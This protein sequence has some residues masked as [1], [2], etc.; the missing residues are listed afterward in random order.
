[1]LTCQ[2][3]GNMPAL[4]CQYHGW[5]FKDDGRPSKILEPRAFRPWDRENALLIPVRLEKVGGLYFATLDQELPSLREWLGQFYE[6]IEARYSAPAWKMAE[7]WEFDAPCNWKVPIENTLESYHIAE[8][9]PTW[10]G[11]LLPDE[12][13]SEHTL[14]DEWTTLRYRGDADPKGRAAWVTKQLGGDVTHFYHHWHIHPN[15]TFVMTDTFNY[16]AS[17][18][19]TGPMTCRVRTRMFPLWGTGGSPWR[20]FVRQTA[21]IV[22][23]RIMKTIFNEDRTVYE[24]QQRGIT[25][26]EHRGVIGI[27][28]ERIYQFQKYVCERTGVAPEID[29][30]IEAEEI[31]QQQGQNLSNEEMV[32]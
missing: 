15:V 24:A 19:P 8:V 32:S 18:V 4:K 20:H 30:A 26:S 3:T 28:E 13:L 22:G 7:A 12:K 9:H 6:T 21:W 5:Q 29:P 17:V 25:H 2:A 31:S 23:R 11:G 16:M 1:M 27:R 10:M 14:D